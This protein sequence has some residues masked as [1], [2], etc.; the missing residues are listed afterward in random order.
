VHAWI[1]KLPEEAIAR[2]S[3]T[4]NV[5]GR[6]GLAPV[7]LYSESAYLSMIH[8]RYT[9]TSVPRFEVIPS[10]RKLG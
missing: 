10:S 8:R 7:P 4:L 3:V 6:V 5:R 1:K 2:A 9:L